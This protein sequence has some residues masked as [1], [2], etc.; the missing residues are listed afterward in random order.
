[1]CSRHEV[2][3]EE[4]LWQVVSDAIKAGTEDELR[5]AFI[6]AFVNNMVEQKLLD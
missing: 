2:A 1:M 4:H 5:D 6:R 3:T